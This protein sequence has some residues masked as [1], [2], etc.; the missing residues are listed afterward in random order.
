[1]ELDE[2]K[3][4]MRERRIVHAGLSARQRNLTVLAHAVAL[5]FVFAAESDGDGR[6]IIEPL[7]ACTH[8][9]YCKSYGH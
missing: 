7:V 8:C 6:C 5:T 4:W 3:E 9:G 1:M 2:L